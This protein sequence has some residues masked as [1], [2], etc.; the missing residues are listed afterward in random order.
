MDSTVYGLRQVAGH[1]PLM[2]SGANYSY[3]SLPI[4]FLPIQ[5]LIDWF[6]TTK[7]CTRLN[8]SS[9]GVGLIPVFRQTFC[10]VEIFVADVSLL[11]FFCAYA[12]VRYIISRFLE[13]ST[14]LHRSDQRKEVRSNIQ[15][16]MV[17]SSDLM[18][19]RF[20]TEWILCIF[21]LVRRKSFWDIDYFVEGKVTPCEISLFERGDFRVKLCLCLC[22]LS[23]FPS[24]H[25]LP[26]CPSVCLSLPA[27]LCLSSLGYRP[28]LVRDASFSAYKGMCHQGRGFRLQQ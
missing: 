8:Y 7:S 20:K 12:I 25:S 10:G 26:L 9:C 16:C 15:R 27:C 24:P 4:G 6:F 1:E 22:P 5:T 17:T 2:Q 21:L 19:N 28:G 11:Q 3:I 23:H 14:K 13:T 18:M